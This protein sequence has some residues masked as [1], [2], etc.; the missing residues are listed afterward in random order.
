[1]NRQPDRLVLI[2]LEN[3]AEIVFA[4]IAESRDDTGNVHH[5]EETRVILDRS[6]RGELLQGYRVHPRIE[7]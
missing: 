6:L 5:R 7:R 4:V 2:G 1:V 3:E